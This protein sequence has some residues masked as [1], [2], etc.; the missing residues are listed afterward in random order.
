MKAR[1]S[2]DINLPDFRGIEDEES[3]RG[4]MIGLV[5]EPARKAALTKLHEA[6]RMDAPP[7]EKSVAMSLPLMAMTLTMALEAGISVEITEPV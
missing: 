7:A 1:I 4:A 6:R 3:L 2:F 5:I